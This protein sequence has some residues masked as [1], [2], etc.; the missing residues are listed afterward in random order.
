MRPL[1][2]LVTV[3]WVFLLVTVGSSV[4]S[5]QNSLPP[6]E[7]VHPVYNSTY[8][9]YDSAWSNNLRLRLIRVPN[10]QRYRIIL[11]DRN[12]VD[13]FDQVMNVSQGMPMPPEQ[14]PTPPGPP[15]PQSVLFNIPVPASQQGQ[16]NFVRVRSVANDNSVSQGSRE[17]RFIVLPTAPA[18]SGPSHPS[19]LPAD[20]T[21][22]FSW[23]PSNLKVPGLGSPLANDFQLTILTGAPEEVSWNPFNPAGVAPPNQSISLSTGSNCPIVPGES[24]MRRCH[25]LTLPAVPT[26]FIWTMARCATFTTDP[27]HPQEQG[28]GRRCGSGSPFRTLSAAGGMTGTFAS[29]ADTFRN[30]RCVNCHALVPSNFSFPSFGVSHPVSVT[31]QTNNNPTA[32]CT[33][34]HSRPVLNT[35]V[36]PTHTRWH[37]PSGMDFRGLGNQQLCQRARGSGNGQAVLQHLLEDELILWAVSDGVLPA[38][39]RGGGAAQ[40]GSISAWRNLVQAWVNAGMPCS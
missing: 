6:P 38:G 16:V 9:G 26:A 18:I 17:Q 4:V 12:R 24:T 2:V 10:V 5:A 14:T 28:K 36:G 25:T 15:I 22:T 21:V 13:Y 40:P 37:G 31:A 39:A 7:I 23:M 11:S 30:P 3:S 34:C 1:F 19:T 33:G 32:N 20:R 27:S 29:L 35:Q 8:P